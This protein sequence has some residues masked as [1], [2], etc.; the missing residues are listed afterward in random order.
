LLNNQGWTVPLQG[1]A[2]ADAIIS[3]QILRL[4]RRAMLF[5][6]SR[7]GHGQHAEI[8]GQPQCGHVAL[9]PLADLDARVE[10]AGPTPSGKSVEAADEGENRKHAAISWVVRRWADLETFACAICD[11]PSDCRDLLHG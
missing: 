2:V 11:V 8:V 5:Q 4:R 10:A 9:D 1:V 7:R 6:I 3:V